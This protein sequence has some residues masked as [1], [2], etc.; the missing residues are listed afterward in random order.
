MLVH[1]DRSRSCRHVERLKQWDN[2]TT[3]DRHDHL[4]GRR[5]P[6]TPSNSQSK[7]HS[8]I[9][10]ALIVLSIIKEYVVGPPLHCLL[11]S[12]TNFGADLIARHF[13]ICG[14]HS[15]SNYRRFCSG[16]KWKNF[17]CDVW[18][19][20]HFSVIETS[21]FENSSEGTIG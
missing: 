3:D 7:T 6:F 12:C 14:R 19:D 11:I 13:R 17:I 5:Q 9:N 15:G 10:I 18:I 2:M 8:P 1:L 21:H 4:R 16:F 20:K